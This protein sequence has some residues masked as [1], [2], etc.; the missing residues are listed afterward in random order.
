MNIP[1]QLLSLLAGAIIAVPT[2]ALLWLG[3]RL[4]L[5]R[6]PAERSIGRVATLSLVSSLLLS[7]LVIGGMW[8]TGQ[9]K[10]VFELGEWF[11]LGKYRF[12]FAL[13]LDWLSLP[14]LLLTCVL[15][16]V[17]AH[18]SASY[19]HRDPGHARFYLLLLLFAVGMLLLV[20]ARSID[21]LFA[22]WELVGLSSALLI[23]FFHRRT[24]PVLNGLRAWAIYRVCDVSLLVAAVMIHHYA[25]SAQFDIVFGG[26]G[27]LGGPGAMTGEAADVVALLLVLAALGK[28]AQIPL[29]GW[30]PRAMEG[31]T[32]SSAIF[33]G[34]LSIHAGA[35]LLLRASPVIQQSPAAQIAL[36][37]VGVSTAL[38]AT[39]VGRVQTDAKNQL[40]YAAMAQVGLIM[41]EIGLG[42]HAIA[43]MHVLGH[44]AIR[45]L[46]FLR[47]PSLLHEFHQVHAAAG[48]DLAPTGGHYEALLPLPL[49]RGL[50]FAA[51]Y[52]FGL[53]SM[54]D[55]GFIRPLLGFAR[56]LDRLEEKYAAVFDAHDSD[57]AQQPGSSA[58]ASVLGE[59][60]K[61]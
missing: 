56:A 53:D 12:G 4:I 22:G 45:T 5:G 14:F 9:D 6:A 32:P 17:V 46:Q 44:A 51:L 26:H 55:R 29:G 42:W 25:N 50:Y 49:R 30:L 13:L 33:Y 37:A 21:L 54:L 2:L 43:L 60:G 1:Q 38:Y 57:A 34:G 24:G 47:A 8:A 10:V 35:Y 52:R 15:T 7:L 31:P 11:A 23:A 39:A 18:F 27:W 3:G 58:V 61:R 40:A 59:K 36:L 19:L 48:G 16:A 41:L 28:S 20:L